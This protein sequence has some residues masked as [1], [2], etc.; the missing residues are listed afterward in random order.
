[1]VSA[2][3]ARL[4]GHIG[5]KESTKILAGFK[6]LEVGPLET[7]EGEKDYPIIRIWIPELLLSPHARF[8]GEGAMTL[9]VTV[10]TS[11]KLGLVNWIETVEKVLDAIEKDHTT[12]EIGLSLNNT[13]EVPMVPQ[14]R[15]NFAPE[16]GLSINALI[17][18][19]V[20]PKLFTRGNR[21][22]T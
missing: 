10:A 17:T 18:L 4:T 1:M 14:V 9:M 6:P 7:V 8:V 11:R 5:P 13:L 3:V 12:G 20:M 21:R 22:S 2:L 15:N 19:S 16:N